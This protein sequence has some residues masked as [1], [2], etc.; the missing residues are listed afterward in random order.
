MA[1]RDANKSANAYPLRYEGAF[2]HHKK[3]RRL[4]FLRA[5]DPRHEREEMHK[6]TSFIVEGDDI[7]LL[8]QVLHAHFQRAPMT[9]N[10]SSHAPPPHGPKHGVSNGAGDTKLVER[11]HETW[12]EHQHPNMRKGK[13]SIDR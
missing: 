2:V 8:Y 5:G 11:P 6:A 4:I 9:R 3:Q 1:K 12:R 10:W 13:R 7:K